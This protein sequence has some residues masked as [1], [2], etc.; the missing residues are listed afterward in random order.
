MKFYR[1]PVNM[2]PSLIPSP[3]LLSDTWIMALLGSMVSVMFLMFSAMLYVWRRQQLHKKT[4]LAGTFT[5]Q[6]KT[7]NN[8]KM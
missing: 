2:K 5:S 1:E 3:E 8:V 6:V 4:F 7:T